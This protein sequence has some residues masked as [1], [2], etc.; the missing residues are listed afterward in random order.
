[1]AGRVLGDDGVK[2]CY[3]TCGIC[4]RF[5]STGIG[6]S[7]RSLKCDVDRADPDIRRHGRFAGT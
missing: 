7:F 3:L 4:S 6:W 1:M 2:Y 5:V